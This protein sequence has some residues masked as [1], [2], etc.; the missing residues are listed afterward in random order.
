LKEVPKEKHHLAAHAISRGASGVLE[1]EGYLAHK[2]PHPPLGPPKGPM[3]IP[4][5][6]SYGVAVSYER[7]TP[8]MKPPPFQVDPS[9]LEGRTL[10][11]VQRG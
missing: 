3:H 4:T 8:V 9:F 11:E 5:V 6:G 2:K 7:G 1:S 10:E